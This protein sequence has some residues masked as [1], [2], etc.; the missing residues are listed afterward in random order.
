MKKNISISNIDERTLCAYLCNKN[1]L[2]DFEI[3]YD[4]YKNISYS[5]LRSKNYE[6]YQ[7]KLQ[8]FISALQ[9]DG[10]SINISKVKH[11]CNKYN[12]DLYNILLLIY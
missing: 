9:S 1:N 3:L 5:A 7:L 11:V 10:D 8:W 2:E 12:I 4:L 6:A